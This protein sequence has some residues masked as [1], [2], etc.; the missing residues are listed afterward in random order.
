ME[1]YEGMDQTMTM[2][3]RGRVR[4]I[5]FLVAILAALIGLWLSN[6]QQARTLKRALEY[7]YLRAVGDLAGSV[8]NIRTTLNKGMYAGTS[9]MLTSLSGKLWTDAS[10]AKVSL[11]QLPVGEFN[12]ENTYKFLSQVGD[13]SQS[14]AKEVAAGRKLTADE[15]KNVETLFDYCSTLSEQ[16]WDLEEKLQNGYISFD[17]TKT[18]LANTSDPQ[19]PTVAEGFQSF[20]EG[21][22]AYPTLIYDGPFSD[23]I[24]EREPIMTKDAPVVAREDARKKAALCMQL[25]V[26]DLQDDEDEAGKMPSY[27]FKTENGT[28]AITKNGGLISYMLKSRAVEGASMTADDAIVKA[29][30]FLSSLGIGDLKHTFYQIAG[31]TCTINF[32]G[33]EGDVTLYTDLIKVA[34][35]LDNGEILSYDARGYIVNHQA[36]SLAEPKLSVRE[37]EDIVS[38]NLQILGSGLALIPSGGLNE[39]FAYEFE[40]VDKNGQKVLVYINAETG[41]EEQILILV[42]SDGGILTV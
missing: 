6:Y 20:E 16:L 23:H 11:S 8:D 1:L 4:I 3:K 26:G 5:S 35:A 27:V 28:S 18:L 37:A 10:S 30:E 41:R 17:K 32:A 39:V 21:F 38:E 40:C 31:N 7:S 24:L 29:R 14:L 9:T 22:K 42:I 34:V 13:Y 33:I 2:T 36:R 15:Q 19:T 25:P 12:L